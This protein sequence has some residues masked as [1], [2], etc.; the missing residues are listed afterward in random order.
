[1]LRVYAS[2]LAKTNALAQSRMQ[3]AMSHYKTTYSTISSPQERKHYAR[4][5]ER[6]S[7][8]SFFELT[9]ILQGRNA[10]GQR[11]QSSTQSGLYHSPFAQEKRWADTSGRKGRGKAVPS[12]Y[13][14][15]G[16]DVYIPVPNEEVEFLT[17]KPN[18]RPVSIGH[19]SGDRSRSTKS[20][21][22][23]EV[24]RDVATNISKLFQIRIEENNR[25]NK[26]CVTALK[27]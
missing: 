10:T 6:W 5:K 25:H 8:A 22:T 20:Q 14:P 27:V 17:T 12:S 1:M 4:F 2:K 11:A 9:E 3:S 19:S 21:K 13:D 7:C 24:L 18:N 23:G 16:D 26:C 15:R